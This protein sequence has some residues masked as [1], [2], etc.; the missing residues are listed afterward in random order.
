MKFNPWSNPTC[1]E[2]NHVITKPR[3]SL[4]SLR[5]RIWAW[6]DTILT[7]A[8]VLPDVRNFTTSCCGC[9][10][11]PSF[12]WPRDQ[13]KRGLWE[14]EWSMSR[15]NINYCA[16]VTG[17][18]KFHDIRLWLLPEPFVSLTTWPKE[19][20][21]LGTRMSLYPTET[22]ISSGRNGPLG[23]YDLTIAGT[24]HLLVVACLTLWSIVW[25]ELFK[26]FKLHVFKLH[27]PSPPSLFFHC[28][29]RV[30][31]AWMSSCGS[32]WLGCGKWQP[33]QHLLF[34]DQLW[35]CL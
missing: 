23:S 12:R 20:R 30:K 27:A 8:H 3:M 10:Q 19:T 32:S 15:Y 26:V 16:C 7:T 2:I 21:A 34:T 33:W 31:G 5:I 35:S 9:Y 24:E 13:K 28:W 22:E 1:S 11:S 4:F 14:R 25:A 6:A 29:V 17:C 18:P